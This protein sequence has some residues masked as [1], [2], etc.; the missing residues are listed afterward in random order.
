[1]CERHVALEPTCTPRPPQFALTAA[2]CELQPG[3]VINTARPQFYCDDPDKL[4]SR[5]AAR[6]NHLCGSHPW[7]PTR[8]LA[9]AVVWG[10]LADVPKSKTDNMG[11]AASSC[12]VPRACALLVDDRPENIQAV[13]RAGYTGI[14]VDER[15]GI[16]S[17]VARD[18]ME[19]L[20][21]CAHE[22][23]LPGAS[24]SGT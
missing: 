3:S 14:L 21:R 10:M 18:I 12:S 7:L 15:R 4:T 6:E 22:A 20:K 24:R 1:M 19:H 23:S 2:H 5:L 17:A 9:G 11:V 16:T 8:S 13:E